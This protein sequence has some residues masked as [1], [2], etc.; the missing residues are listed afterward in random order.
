MLKSFGVLCGGNNGGVV[1]AREILVAVGE[2]VRRVLIVGADTDVRLITCVCSR[3][4]QAAR[5]PTPVSRGA[6]V[7]SG[8]S[9]SCRRGGGS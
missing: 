6:G 7:T 9:Q 3:I 4:G 8:H 5:H 1:I 2:V